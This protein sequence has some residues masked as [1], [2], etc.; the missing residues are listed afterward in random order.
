MGHGAT[1]HKHIGEATIEDAANPIVGA[2]LCV[3]PR[4]THNLKSTQ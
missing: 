4:M 3:R 1:P 2:N